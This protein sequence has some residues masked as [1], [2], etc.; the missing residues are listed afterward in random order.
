MHSVKWILCLALVLTAHP[1]LAAPGG[2]YGAGK[3]TVGIQSDSNSLQLLIRLG[4][5]QYQRE[6]HWI[7]YPDLFEF[8][9]S[10]EHW[11]GQFLRNGEVLLTTPKGR[12]VVWKPLN[13]APREATKPAVSTPP[14][15]FLGYGSW[16]SSSGNRV[17][18]RSRQGRVFVDV[19]YR[20]GSNRTVEAELLSKTRFRY[21][22]AQDEVYDCEVLRNG[23]VR[24]FRISTGKAT[25]WTRISGGL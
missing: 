11:T 14:P 12:Q 3:E 1:C 4:S 10:N 17:T 9:H 18:L 20:T 15:A 21:A 5:Q 24:C 19:V 22:T 13:G 2:W 7:R 25:T 23:T 16:Q 8:D 6:G